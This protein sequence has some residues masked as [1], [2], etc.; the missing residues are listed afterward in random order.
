MPR[1]FITLLATGHLICPLALLHE[2]MSSRRVFG[3]SSFRLFVC[4][5]TIYLFVR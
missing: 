4:L 1:P 5:C 2:E 3:D